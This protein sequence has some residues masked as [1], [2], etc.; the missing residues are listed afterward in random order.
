MRG[1]TVRWE[2]TGP[3]GIYRGRGFVTEGSSL[4]GLLCS[5]AHN[6]ARQEGPTRRPAGAG[7]VLSASQPPELLVLINY[8]L[9]VH[10][11]KVVLRTTPTH[12]SSFA[13]GH[14]QRLENA[15]SRPENA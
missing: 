3:C 5:P 12:G 14:G 6:P 2:A 15:K 7:A 1:E 4:A 10:A 8:L 13:I 9:Q 11:Q